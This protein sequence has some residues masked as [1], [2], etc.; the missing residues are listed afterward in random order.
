MPPKEK[1]R[2]DAE[3]IPNIHVRQDNLESTPQL[4]TRQV[5]SLARRFPI[6]AAM[7]EA[8]APMIF[9]VLS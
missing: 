5:I 6:N 4:L 7:A 1:A 9:G 3:P 2:Q 8:L